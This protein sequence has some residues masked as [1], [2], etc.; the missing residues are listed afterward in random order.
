MESI[1][2][3]ASGDDAAR[4]HRELLDEE[5]REVVAA[6]RGGEGMRTIWQQE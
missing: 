2:G 3:E 6:V 1:G 4:I 5:R